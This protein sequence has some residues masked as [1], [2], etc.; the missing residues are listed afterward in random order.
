M[1]SIGQQAVALVRNKFERYYDSLEQDY[2]ERKKRL[3]QFTDN[4]HSNITNNS[5]A[6]NAIMQ[7]QQSKENDYLRFK[8][9]RLS[10]NSDFRTIKVIG[11]GAFGVVKLVQKL[12]TGRVYAMKVMRKADMLAFQQAGHVRA[13]RDLLVESRSPWVVQLHYSLQDRDHLYLV[14]EFVPGGDLMGLLI[15]LDIFPEPMA[16]FYA[17]QCVQAIAS[18]HELGFIHRDIKPDN[19]LIDARGHVKLT[20]FGLSTGFHPLHDTNYWTCS[21]DRNQP[22]PT[23]KSTATSTDNALEW[24]EARRKIAYSAVGTPDYIAP[25]VFGKRGYGPE[26]DWW[27]LGAIVYEMLVGFP[28][29]HAKTPAETYMKIQNWRHHLHF[30]PEPKLTPAARNFC[31]R[32]LCDA[33]HRLGSGGGGVEEIRQHPFFQGVDWNS[34]SQVK[35]PFIPTLSSMTD[36]SHFPVDEIPQQ[37]AGP[38]DSRSSRVSTMDKDCAFV[39][40]TFKRF[41]TISQHF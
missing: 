35:A 15:K 4:Y 10:P 13:E 20:D 8:R 41:E 37:G 39:G 17:A 36:C 29:F 6:S 14:M 11:R 30:P 21:N 1:P 31:Q 25:E 40:Y 9:V 33:E 18:V 19:I 2:E 12:D 28:P 38:L 23:S 16:R 34:L 22:A 24:R 26:C 3:V 7:H 5:N 32:L 27:S